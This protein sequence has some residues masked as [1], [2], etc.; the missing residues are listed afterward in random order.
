MRYVQWSYVTRCASLVLN[1]SFH[2]NLWRRVIPL[3]EMHN[4][5]NDIIMSAMASQITSLT[6]VCSTVYSRRRS[7]K[8]SELR[9]TGLCE[10]NYPV[11][12]EFPHKGPVTRK[13]FPFDDVIM[14]SSL[15]L[16][17]FNCTRHFTN[18]SWNI[19][20]ITHVCQKYIGFVHGT[21]KH[22]RIYTDAMLPEFIVTYIY[23]YIY[24]YTYVYLLLQI[25]FLSEGYK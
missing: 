3:K 8:T 25:S 9:V 24:I 16:S 21:A 7:K 17:V 2:G 22:L 23:I 19:I 13:M 11:T 15:Y 1:E 18:R 5:Y 6:I 14:K 12:G 10:W 4:H 20:T